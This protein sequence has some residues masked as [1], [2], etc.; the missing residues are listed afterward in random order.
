MIG[1]ESFLFLD[2]SLTDQ[3]SDLPFISHKSVVTI[4]HGWILFAGTHLDGIT[5][6]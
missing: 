6:E 2:H 5:Y 3:R 4:T 1:S